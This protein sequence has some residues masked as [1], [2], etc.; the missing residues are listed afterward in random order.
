VLPL[1]L[2]A[3]L[4]GAVA[5]LVQLALGRSEPGPAPASRPGQG[6]DDEEW[7]PPRHSI[8]FG[9]FLALAA[10]EW[11]YLAPRLARLVPGFEL[12]V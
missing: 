11:L 3:S 1:L 10:I 9:P 2:L 7:T 5:G 8:P 6:T 4:Q 12:F